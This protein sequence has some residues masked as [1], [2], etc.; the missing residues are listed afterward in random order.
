VPTDGAV[1]TVASNATFE[2]DPV[3]FRDNEATNVLRLVRRQLTN[4]RST[5][6][7]ATA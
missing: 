6:F 3:A 2:A 7:F 5:P 1:V 4:T